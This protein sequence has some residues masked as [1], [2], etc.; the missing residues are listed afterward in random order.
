MFTQRFDIARHQF[1]RTWWTEGNKT[2]SFRQVEDGFWLPAQEMCIQVLLILIAWNMAQVR[3]VHRLGMDDR[4]EV[5]TRLA[6]LIVMYGKMGIEFAGHSLESA[7]IRRI[8]FASFAAFIDNDAS[9]I[10]S[11]FVNDLAQATSRTADKESC[12]CHFGDGLRQFD[13]FNQWETRAD[14]HWP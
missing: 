5:R 9:D 8:E 2:N 4:M 14:F 12:V 13:F 1:S 3:Q 11:W 6:D 10:G 7:V